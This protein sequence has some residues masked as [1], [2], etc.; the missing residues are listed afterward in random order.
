MTILLPHACVCSV[1]LSQIAERGIKLVI[2]DSVA[3]LVRSEY[4]DKD[5]LLERQE[6]LGRQAASL[7]RLAEQYRIPV[8]VTNQVTARPIGAATHDFQAVAGQ[9][10][11]GTS[12]Y[13]SNSSVDQGQLTAALGTKWAHCVNVRLVLERMGPHRYIKI[14]KSP[15]SANLVFEY[16]ISN[17]GLQEVTNT[18]GIPMALQ[19]SA[20]NVSIANEMGPDFG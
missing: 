12:S 3:A 17:E 7:K 18:G 10:Q 19:E 13:Q 15:I 4:G 2:V 11:P 6:L 9:L 16:T 1:I 20:I 5:K 8:V 14:A